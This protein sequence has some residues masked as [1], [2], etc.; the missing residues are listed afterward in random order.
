MASS[1]D[2]ASNRENKI[3]ARSM[4]PTKRGRARDMKPQNVLLSTGDVKIMDFGI[5]RVADMK[6]M[7]STER[8]WEP[9][10]YMSPE[11]AQ[12]FAVDHERMSIRQASCCSKCYRESFPLLQ[13][14]RL[15]C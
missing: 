13:I 15:L 5:A 11:Q 6:G 9:L 14:Q 12:G 2:R 8:L 4:R 7:T 3:A 1:P 10:H